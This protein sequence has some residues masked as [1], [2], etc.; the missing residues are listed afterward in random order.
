MSSVLLGLSAVAWIAQ[1]VAAVQTRLVRLQAHEAVPPPDSF[2]AFTVVFIFGIGLVT[3][4]GALALLVLALLNP[5]GRQWA[6]IVTWII[7]GVMLVPAGCGLALSR[8]P[9]SGSE[10]PSTIDWDRIAEVTDELM[11]AWV[12]PVA[13][14][15]GL[16]A[17][18]ALLAAVVLLALPRSND[19][20][21]SR[22]AG[23]FA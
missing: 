20:Y 19:F 5:T 21:R 17:S 2:T 23:A 11:P 3:A 12:E 1:A 14:V 4:L 15:S 22:R 8:L 6:R 16:L 18:P 13:T 9:A 7:G 10:T